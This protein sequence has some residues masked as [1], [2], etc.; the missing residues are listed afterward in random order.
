MTENRFQGLPF[1]EIAR[2]LV[3]DSYN[4]NNDKTNGNHLGV[5]QVYVIWSCYT[6]GSWKCGLS[7]QIPDGK[8]YEVTYNK[9]R[10]EV[11]IDTYVKFRNEELK[12]EL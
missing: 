4:N 9:A 7:T 6:L 12:L 1:T 10:G 8:E 11:Y 3:A 2:Q 5:H